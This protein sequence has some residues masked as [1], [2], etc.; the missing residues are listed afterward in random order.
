MHLGECLVKIGKFEEASKTFQDVLDLLHSSPEF[1]AEVVKSGKVQVEI[2]EPNARNYLN[3]LKG[4]LISFANYDSPGVK[5]LHNAQQA[6]ISE[7]FKLAL[8]SVKKAM[9]LFNGTS[10]DATQRCLLVQGKSYAGLKMYENA[11]SNFRKSIEIA[12]RLKLDCWVAASSLALMKCYL[13]IDYLPE[14]TELCD[15]LTCLHICRGLKQDSDIVTTLEPYLKSKR[16]DALFKVFDNFFHCVDT[17]DMEDK[18][19]QLFALVHKA[20]AQFLLKD[21]ETAKTSFQQILQDF[22]DDRSKLKFMALLYF[23]NTL[24][25]LGESSDLINKVFDEALDTFESMDN[26]KLG[27]RDRRFSLADLHRQSLIK[28]LRSSLLLNKCVVQMEKNKKADP[29]KILNLLNRQLVT[30]GIFNT[31]VES[32]VKKILKLMMKQYKLLGLESVQP[33]N[34]VNSI[35]IIQHFKSSL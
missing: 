23:G 34:Y 29:N 19:R 14:C 27:C 18:G 26:K 6:I 22:K 3:E 4:G 9:I 7:D 33:E 16:F 20:M 2:H 12:K 28:P 1:Y 31:I 30:T 17:L 8:D 10:E 5:M 32:D 11:I 35:C 21:Y 24:R 15:E 25:Q 13:K